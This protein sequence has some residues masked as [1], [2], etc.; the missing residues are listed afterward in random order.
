[1]TYND[2]LIAQMNDHLMSFSTVTFGDCRLDLKSRLLSRKGEAVHLTTKAYELLG[3]L[4]ARRPNV[5][6]KQ[7]IM[8]HLWPDTFVAESNIPNLI[9]EIR[10]AI[11]DASGQ[12]RFIRTV[13]RVGYV[14]F[15]PADAFD[16]T[17]P[18]L[19]SGCWLVIDGRDVPLAHGENFIGRD[20]TCQITAYSSS[21]SR[22]HASVKV[23]SEAALIADL[24][25]KNGTYV[26]GIRLTREARLSDGDEIQ[27]GEV[28]MKFRALERDRTTSSFWPDQQDSAA[29]SEAQCASADALDQKEDRQK[30]P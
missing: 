1:V 27:I 3:L 4:I 12:C 21:V 10:E 6:T 2:R 24:G 25:S 13:H 26:C 23:D 16:D 5:V 18:G 8:D 22:R 29:S 28:K 19:N 30:S 9:A 17:P 11:D 20:E 14:F 7:E 15:G